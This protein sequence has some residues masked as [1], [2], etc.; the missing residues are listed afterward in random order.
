MRIG[1]ARVST[2]E[3]NLDLQLDALRQAGCER[4]FEDR[5]SGARAERPGWEQLK[6][7]L[8]EGDTVVVWRLDRLGRSLKHL[9]DVV[10]ELSESGVG[11]QSLAESL[12]TTTNGGKLVFHIFGALA[13]FERGIIRERTLAGL[14]SARARG[15][16]GGRPK[17][18]TEKKLAYARQL[19]VDP[20]NSVADVAR[21]LGVGRATLYRALGSASPPRSGRAE[22]KA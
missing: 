19:L 2:H 4:I 10:T 21:T 16:K 22:R 20:N 6:L 5:I 18:L 1:Y 11:F 13:E 14:A 9:I 3:Q 15:R 8:R 7:A 17:K 12:D